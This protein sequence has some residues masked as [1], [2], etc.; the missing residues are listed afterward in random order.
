MQEK[1]CKDPVSHSL[2]ESIKYI[3]QTAE[4]FGECMSREKSKL[5]RANKVFHKASD[6]IAEY[7]EKCSGIKDGGSCEEVSNFMYPLAFWLS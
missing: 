3:D 1:K 7:K 6:I 2:V 5:I 4:A